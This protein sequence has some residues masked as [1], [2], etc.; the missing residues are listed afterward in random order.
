MSLEEEKSL[1]AIIAKFNSF[2]KTQINDLNL[3][4]YENHLMNEV[5]R[6]VNTTRDCY[7]LEEGKD[8][9]GVLIVDNAGNIKGNYLFNEVIVRGVKILHL[10]LSCLS[11]ESNFRGKGISNFLR[12][13]AFDYALKNDYA[14]ITSWALGEIEFDILETKIGFDCQGVEGRDLIQHLGIDYKLN[15]ILDIEKKRSKLEDI[16]SDFFSGKKNPR[17]IIVKP[18]IS[19][20]IS[21]KEP[22]TSKTP[23]PFEFAREKLSTTSRK[24]VSDTI[25]RSLQNVKVTNPLSTRR[26]RGGRRSR[27]RNKFRRIKSKKM[28]KL[29]RTKY[30]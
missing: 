4:K 6:F 5:N 26:R 25:P 12:N 1:D 17:Q 10:E 11:S 21:S 30:K 27:Y 28:K 18:P 7:S 13:I 20:V 16:I 15:C 29:R 2:L 23:N 14:Y 24:P 9:I 8:Y 22:E 3:I 19:A